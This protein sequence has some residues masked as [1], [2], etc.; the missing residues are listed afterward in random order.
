MTK[1]I[2][3]LLPLLFPVLTLAT[4]TLKLNVADENSTNRVERFDE[5]NKCFQKDKD[6]LKSSFVDMTNNTQF[7]SEEAYLIRS[8]RLL[9]ERYEILK[10]S[11][12]EHGVFE[13]AQRESLHQI[14]SL[15]SLVTDIKVI[16]DKK[17]LHMLLSR[18]ENEIKAQIDQLKKK[19]NYVSM[20][21]EYLKKVPLAENTFETVILRG[22]MEILVSPVERSFDPTN[23][24]ILLSLL[25]YPDL[26][27]LVFSNRTRTIDDLSLPDNWKRNFC[28]YAVFK[29]LL[30]LEDIRSAVPSHALKIKVVRAQR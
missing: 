20:I 6:V 7:N 11:K 10:T 1:K 30:K 5:F 8:L 22:I 26:N 13:K 23:P 4:P 18:A 21:P 12:I 3:F 25:K 29:S 9:Q 2:T 14:K 19:G 27:E 28:E 24:R 16:T 15:Q 17:Y